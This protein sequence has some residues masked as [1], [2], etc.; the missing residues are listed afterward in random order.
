LRELVADDVYGSK[1]ARVPRR[2]RRGKQ[3]WFLFVQPLERE[4]TARRCASL[5]DIPRARLRL[6][7]GGRALTT[8]EE[9]AAASDAGAR[10]MVL[11][12]KR[13]DIVVTTSLLE[14]VAVVARGGFP[15][16]LAFFLNL[17]TSRVFIRGV[18]FARRA[19]RRVL[20][21][22][23]PFVSAF[24]RSI[25][26]GWENPYQAAFEARRNGAAAPGGRAPAR[27]GPL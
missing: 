21:P 6:M 12:S 3:D 15:L 17:P 2:V 9:I 27:R 22:A 16:F 1:S 19:G 7:A 25:H 4:A 13:E 24:L 14:K 23:Y 20:A 11:G 5:F 10:V 18:L 26:P 8:E